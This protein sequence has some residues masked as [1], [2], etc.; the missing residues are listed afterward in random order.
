M[1]PPD[2][3]APDAGG[4]AV[5]RAVGDLDRILIVLE[6]DHAGDRTEDLLLRD[7]H[8]GIDPREH[9]WLDEESN[10]AAPGTPR[11]DSAAFAPADIDIAE[12]ALHL[13]FRN[14]RPHRRRGAAGVAEP[15]RS[16]SRR[17]SWDHP[18]LYGV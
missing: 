9:G 3:G 13:H 5:V 12:H 1:N 16:C 17:E 2:V 4:K 11:H 18:L 6:G 14:D 8:G 15:Y 7:A 10:L